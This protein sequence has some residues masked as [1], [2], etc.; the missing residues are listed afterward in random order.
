MIQVPS[1]HRQ[2]V[3]RAALLTSTTLCL[4]PLTPVQAA[5]TGARVGEQET[6]PAAMEPSMQV[7]NTPPALDKLHY[8]ATPPET[9]ATVETAPKALARSVGENI[10]KHHQAFTE[11]SSLQS[12]LPSKQEFLEATPVSLHTSANL[13]V[14]D[15]T[16]AQLVSAAD[17]TESLRQQLLIEPLVELRVPGFAPGSTAGGPSAFGADFGDAYVGISGATRRARRNGADGSISAGFGLGDANKYAG[18]EVNLNIGSLRRFAANGDVG[19]KLHRN[20]SRDTAIAVGWDTGIRWGDENRNVD[21]TLYGVATKVFALDTEDPKRK[22]PLTVSVGFGGG[23][24][25]SFESEQRGRNTVGMFGS[26][27]LQVTPQSSLVSTW[28]GRDLNLGISLVP[29]RTK[30]F[31]VTAVVANVFGRDDASTLYSLSLGYGFNFSG[32]R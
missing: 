16:V 26:V 21:S 23:R 2:R 30:P 32:S 22:L 6:P 18:L 20:L 10:I 27:G 13:S 29:I 4:Y 17:D 11:K 24:F 31:F 8:P 1:H 9:I 15:A 3:L 14:A 12:N 7:V 19:L 25:R 28:T 5:E